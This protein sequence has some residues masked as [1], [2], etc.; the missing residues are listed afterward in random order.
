MKDKIN[1]GAEVIREALRKRAVKL[2]MAAVLKELGVPSNLYDAFLAGGDLPAETK[3]AF[4][5]CLFGGHVI[6]DPATDK[7]MA[8]NKAPPSTMTKR[9]LVTGSVTKTSGLKL[10]QA[11]EPPKQPGWT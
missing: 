2:N 9:P 3:Q 10:P 7:L 1:S 6:Y 11:P 8:T 4:V 5:T